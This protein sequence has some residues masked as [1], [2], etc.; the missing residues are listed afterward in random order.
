MKPSISFVLVVTFALSFSVEAQT[1]SSVWGQCGGIQYSGPTCC[2]SGS[3]C[4]NYG[5]IYYSQCVPGSESSSTTSKTTSSTS[6]KTSTKTTTTTSAVLTSSKTTTTTSTKTTTT[7]SAVATTSG[8]VSASGGN[9]V[10][11]GC[12]KHFSGTNSYQLTFNNYAMIDEELNMLASNHPGL[13]LIRTWAFCEESNCPSGQVLSFSGS[14]V[15]INAA[16]GTLLNIDYTLAQAAKKGIK[17]VLVLTNNWADFGGMD[18]YTKALGGTY[19]DDFFT[20]S[21]IKA[22][23]KKY[24]NYLVNR[25]NTITGVA[26]KNDP[27]IFSWEIANEVR[28]VGS[29]LSA[30]SSC[31]ASR[32]TAWYDEISKY[33]KSIDSKHMVATG[34]EG[35]GITAVSGASSAN[36]YIYSTGAGLDFKT[37]LA[38]SAIDY[39][40]AHLYPVGWGLSNPA[41]DGNDW[42]KAHAVAATSV[43]KPWVLEEFGIT[44]KSTRASVY[45]SWYATGITSGVGAMQFWTCAGPSY[46][47]YD[48]YTLY[49]A[50]ISS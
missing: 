1:C 6:S 43:G 15:T 12:K 25:V 47:D 2:E 39:G 21:T 29:G 3:V 32:I 4:T 40:T 13:N 31:S 23:F 16:S 45:A 42:I 17:I 46:G 49:D 27:T 36:N 26:Y 50:E 34:D 35:F 44:D 7:T 24:I 33:I 5:N 11:N 8:I 20:S 37:N 10:V 18:T 48:G 28:C 14:T 9:F 19:H 38:L 41:T 22:A 30:S